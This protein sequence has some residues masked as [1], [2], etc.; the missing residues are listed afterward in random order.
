[1]MLRFSEEIKFSFFLFYT[2]TRAVYVSVEAVVVNI[3]Q[4]RL[5]W[6]TTFLYFRVRASIRTFN[7]KQL[8]VNTFKLKKNLQVQ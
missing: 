3:F 5:L 7:P 2:T 4:Y 8:K 1:M 6:Y